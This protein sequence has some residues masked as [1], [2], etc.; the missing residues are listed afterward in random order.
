MSPKVA[1]RIAV[2]IS[3]GPNMNTKTIS[4]A[5]PAAWGDFTKQF[6]GGH[7]V[8]GNVIS[9]LSDRNPYNDR[10]LTEIPLAG[11]SELDAAFDAASRAQLEWEKVLPGERSA[12]LW[13]AVSILERRK[14]EII[15][16]LISESGSTRIKATA[17]WQTAHAG[18]MEAAAMPRMVQGYVFRTDRKGREARAYK[19][20]V[21]VVAVISSW[22]FPFYVSNRSVAP[23]IAFGNAVVLKPSNDTPV[24]GGLLLAKIYEEAGLPRGVLNVI[25]GSSSRIG[26]AFARHPIP[27]LLTYS[28]PT[29]AG[30]HIANI[31]TESTLKRLGLELGGNAPLVVLDDAD[32]PA[33]VEA[34]LFGCLLHQGQI[35]MATNRII[36]DSLIYEE[37]IDA[38]VAA[39]SKVKCGNPNDPDTLI[40]PLC[41]DNQ[42]RSVAAS[43]KLARSAGC[44]ERLCGK[45][46]GRV[47]PPHV[48]SEVANDS[49]FARRELFGPVTPIIRASDEREALAFA[50]QTE[51]GLS[52]SVFTGDS[53]R[54][55]AF[56]KRLETGVVH[57]NDISMHDYP[58]VM[59][60]GE[61]T[62]GLGRINGKSIVDE[63][64]TDHLI[65]VPV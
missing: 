5:T 54:G 53:A 9:V 37:F 8:S 45:F 60:G 44:S 1:P 56:A 36:V 43:I 7:W 20:P 11:I 27:K 24:S 33:A 35:S 21:G 32:V 63:M 31:A 38:Y 52:S 15:G 55:L 42:V 39:A 26:D 4:A 57:V 22:N 29:P 61:K 47:V 51:F 58:F 12:V 30:R 19:K 62:S 17:E 10:L 48:Y 13:N 64:T 50:N 49:D 3:K 23:A 34:A 41:N 28:G 16:W 65:S 2:V 25:I 46:E 6:I 59:S 18:T 14:D 40:G